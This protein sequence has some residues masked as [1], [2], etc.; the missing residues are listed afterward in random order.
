MATA[1]LH[2]TR[3]QEAAETKYVITRSIDFF[4][5]DSSSVTPKFILKTADG[6][7]YV[8]SEMLRNILL[9]FDGTRSLNQVA[10]A[11]SEQ[12]KKSVTGEQMKQ[13]FAG[14]INKY[15]LVD[16]AGKIE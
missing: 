9:L 12:E 13:I 2:A 6:R 14:Y 5:L 16:E 8:I 7:S 1:S 10:D 4:P 15:G 11:I 3:N